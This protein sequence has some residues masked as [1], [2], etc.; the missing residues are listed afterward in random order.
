V[1]LTTDVSNRTCVHDMLLGPAEDEGAVG[2]P[3]GEPKK[4]GG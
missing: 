3:V 4:A 1:T 2:R